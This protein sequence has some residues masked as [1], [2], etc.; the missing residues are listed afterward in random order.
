VSALPDSC[1]SDGLDPL[2]R[3]ETEQIVSA[4]DYN[5]QVRQ[6]RVAV[7]DETAYEGAVS[8]REEI[9]ALLGLRP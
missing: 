2:I 1:E 3:A 6:F 9:E 7:K 8:R 5:E 4:V